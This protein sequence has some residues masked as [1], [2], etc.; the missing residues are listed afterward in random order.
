MVKKIISL[1]LAVGCLAGCGKPQLYKNKFVAIG[2]Y[3][4]IV[5]FDQRAAGIVY[6][7]FK[8]LEKI[9]NFYD[10]QSELALVNASYN[11]PIK[12]SLEMIEV[13]SLA[14]QVTDM[15]QGAFDVSCGAM[16]DFWKELIKKQKVDKLPDVKMIEE[17][18]C[19]CGMDKIIIDK[20]NQTVTVKGMGIEIDLAA[21]AKGY[22]VDKAVQ[23]LK[24][25]GIENVLIN[26]GG[27]IYGLGFN[28]GN[29]WRVGVQNPDSLQ[30]ILETQEISN[31]AVATSGS[32]EQF[33]TINNKRYSHIID[34][35]TAM[36]VDNDLISV[37]V[38]TQ[39]CTTADALAT[40]F[41]VMGK[42]GIKNFLSANSST[43]R[44][45]VVSQDAQ[46]KHIEMFK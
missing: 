22:I 31:E 6:D 18:K 27:E 8:R 4:E 10:P 26:A 41:F 34:P 25:A 9:F 35:R 2:T 46:G 42:A 32:Y 21:I 5:S 39:N 28:Q 23:K 44:I 1:L 40:G 29:P 37:T 20:T 36:P 38:I 30:G 15:T 19:L 24:Q 33:F 43:M 12:V 3:L 16:F 7:E 45:F 14:R 17:L 11:Q 13:L